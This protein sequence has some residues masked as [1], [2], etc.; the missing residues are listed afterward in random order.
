VTDI[1]VILLLAAMVIW[2]LAIFVIVL[3]LKGAQFYD[4]EPFDDD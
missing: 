2:V 3:F 4:R 1:T